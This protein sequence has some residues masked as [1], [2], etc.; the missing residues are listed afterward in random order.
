MSE[1]G[2]PMTIITTQPDHRYLDVSIKFEPRKITIGF[3]NN[4]QAN[5]YHQLMSKE[6]F[7]RD[8]DLNSQVS[9]RSVSLRLPSRV[10]EIVSSSSC[11]GFYIHF[12]DEQLASEWQK[13]LLLW[14][15][16]DGSKTKLYIDRRIGNSLLNEMLGIPEPRPSSSELRSPGEALTSAPPPVYL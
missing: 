11:G 3:R 4:I 7:V 8:M 10:T 9:N 1:R 5:R 15:F 6:P 14:K 13:T 2:G 12:S 16:R